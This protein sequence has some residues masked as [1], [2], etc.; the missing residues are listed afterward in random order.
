M[1]KSAK[2]DKERLHGELEYHLAMYLKDKKTLNYDDLLSVN[3]KFLI[4][5]G[6]AGISKD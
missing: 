4:L 6:I 1:V 2:V 5:R 3:D